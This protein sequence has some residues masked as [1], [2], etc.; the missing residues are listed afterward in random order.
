MELVNWKLKNK[1]DI[2]INKC[3]LEFRST[4]FD[5]IL[6]MLQR[7]YE[8]LVAEK[9]EA[10]ETVEEFIDK[11][12][13]LTEENEN[14]NAETFKLLSRIQELEEINAEVMEANN[15]P[16]QR[17]SLKVDLLTAENRQLKKE[18]NNAHCEIVLLK[19][20]YEL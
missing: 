7:R 16:A 6:E 17:N 18:L 19:I 3:V 10:E 11:I 15:K 4:T 20:K 12:E 8:K 9:A 2:D 13:E 1:I 14:L 5:D